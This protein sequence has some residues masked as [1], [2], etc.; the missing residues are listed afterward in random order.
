MRHHMRL[1][2]DPFNKIKAGTKTIELRLYDEKR[3]KVKLNDEIEFENLETGEKIIV[4][5]RSL[6][7][8]PGFQELYASLPLLKCGYTKETVN[9]AYYTDMETYYPRCE[10]D[11]YGVV[12]IEV[13]RINYKAYAVDL[14]EIAADYIA[15]R[16]DEYPANNCDIEA[17]RSDDSFL[18][19]LANALTHV[20]LDNL[21]G[22]SY[23]IISNYVWSVYEVWKKANS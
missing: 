10:Q 11:K 19:A 8:F 15:D 20:F 9:R 7:I 17:I 4:R 18:N 21:C 3:K 1:R 12:G 6:H 13:Q 14:A 16:T 5:V 23:F 2:N 22:D